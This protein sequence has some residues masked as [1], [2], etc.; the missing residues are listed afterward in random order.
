MPDSIS[1]KLNNKPIAVNTDGNRLLLW[2]LRTDLGLTG[3]K[4]GCG[5]GHCGCCTVL[6]DDVAVR[7]C[8]V[9]LKSVS[10]KSVTTVEGLAANGMPHAIQKGFL[11]HDGFQC[12]FCT[13]GQMLQALSLLKRNPQPTREQIIQ[14]MNNNL[15]RCGAYTRIIDSIQNAAQIMKEMK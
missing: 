4:Y 1:F 5:Q 12:G 2:V 8:L 6:V 9:P 15:C 11:R 13:P 3:A 10:N 14:G 7:S